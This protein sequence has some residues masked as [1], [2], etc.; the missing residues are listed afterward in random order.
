MLSRGS[1]LSGFMATCITADEND[2]GQ[3]KTEVVA[4]RIKYLEAQEVKLRG[5][6]LRQ[7]TPLHFCGNAPNCHHQPIENGKSYRRFLPEQENPRFRS[8][9][10]PVR[11]QVH[12]TG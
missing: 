10:E 12:G 8:L 11:G 5:I 2:G 1:G 4:T 7:A 3:Y 9:T 6:A